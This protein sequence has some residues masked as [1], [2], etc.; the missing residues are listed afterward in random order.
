MDLN[1]RK[2]LKTQIEKNSSF[3]LSKMYMKTKEIEQALQD[4]VENKE[5]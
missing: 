4:V 5:G 1:C 3:R 2:S